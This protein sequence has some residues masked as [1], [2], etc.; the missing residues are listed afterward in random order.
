MFSEFRG[1]D[2][3]RGEGVKVF[4]LRGDLEGVGMWG[5]GGGG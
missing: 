3:K 4:D 5:G 1:R 2:G